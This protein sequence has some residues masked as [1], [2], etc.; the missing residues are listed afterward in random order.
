MPAT[1]SPAPPP[2]TPVEGEVLLTLEQVATL[3]QIS[4]RT[5]GNWAKQGR[6]TPIRNGSRWTRY[7]KAEVERL[8]AGNGV[9]QPNGAN[10]A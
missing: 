9:L 8:L 1:P 5:V 3:L 6:L 7:R 2:F 10:K 4:A